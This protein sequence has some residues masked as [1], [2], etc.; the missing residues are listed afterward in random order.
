MNIVIL[1]WRDIKHPLAGGA[2]QSLAEHAKYWLSRGAYVT[3][4]SSSF[5][6]ASKK[7]TIDGV[8]IIRMGS[9]YTVHIYAFFY[10]IRFLQKQT[11]IVVDCFHFVPFFT[12]LY[13]NRSKILALVNE[14]SKN[15]WFKNII[16]PI[17]IVGYF[18]ERFFFLPYRS[19]QF[20]TSAKSIARELNNYGILSK[21][22]TIIPH[23]FTVTNGKTYKKENIP[24]ILYLSQLAPDKG[25]EDA[26]RAFSLIKKSG[27]NAQFWIAGK[28]KSLEY[29]KIL[30]E[31]AAQGGILKNTIFW[32]F[33]SEEEKWELLS[34]A[35]VLIHPSIRE[36]W[37][38]NIIEA[39]AAATPAVGYNVTGL[40]DSINSMQTGIITENNTPSDLAKN[41]ESLF[42]DKKL[43]Q[44]FAK[45]AVVW[46]K[47]FSWEKAGA[48]S[49]EQIKMIYER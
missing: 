17:S 36:G 7:E 44:K 31:K 18:S 22:I 34:K 12:P 39:N 9:H 19:I 41:I 38:L 10:F 15:A 40:R 5:S 33:V 37:G 47:K 2:E 29:G 43:Y 1:N 24:T 6:G 13:V 8:Q 49:W 32:G 26:I 25:I 30:R 45:N 16:L 21:N 28:E 11:N 20:I 4:I 42:K 23:G 14:P 3:W 27:T 35:W 46:S 48:Q